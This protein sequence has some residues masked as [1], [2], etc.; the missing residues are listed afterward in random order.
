MGQGDRYPGLDDRS[1]MQLERAASSLTGHYGFTRSDLEDIRQ[2]LYLRLHRNL[3]QHDPMKGGKATFVDRVLR[4]AVRDLIRRQVATKRDHAMCTA[5]LDSPY[6]GGYGTL[7]DSITDTDS[8]PSH[9]DRIHLVID[10][11]RVVAGLDQD[12]QS[13]CHA[14]SMQKTPTEIAREHGICRQTFY[15]RRMRLR[16]AFEDA[17]MQVYL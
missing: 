4:S 7:G 2:E 16:R 3:P 12:L 8:T 1:R 10:V 6:P 15:A 5:S 13:L 14:L 11:Q 9:T 17:G